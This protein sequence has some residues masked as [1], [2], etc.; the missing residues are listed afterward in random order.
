ML[1]G[2]PTPRGVENWESL[3]PGERASVVRQAARRLQ[4]SGAHDQLGSGVVRLGHGKRERRSGSAGGG[5]VYEPTPVVVVFVKKKWEESAGQEK[6]GRGAP[7]AVPERLQMRVRV[8]ERRI[9]VAMPTDV[10]QVHPPSLHALQS[11]CVA[12]AEAGGPDLPG[13]VSALVRDV[14]DSGGRLYLL[15]CHHVICR[16]AVTPGATARLDVPIHAVDAGGLRL[17]TGK[18]PAQ[19]G[20]DVLS[21]DAALVLLEDAGKA[22][23]TQRE[24]WRELARSY[25]TDAEHLDVLSHASWRLAS[26]S[27]LKPLEYVRNSFKVEIPYGSDAVKITLAEL[28]ES[29]ATSAPPTGGDSGGAVLAGQVLV[30]VH[31]AGQGAMS[32]A[33]PA[34]QLFSTVAFSPRLELASQLIH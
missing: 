13:S 11:A 22:L 16:S 29:R 31:I 17:G 24:F 21:I 5:V 34:Y 28:I 4:R 6:A 19:F 33:V 20:P 32:F 10:C 23:V 12:A 15:G 8:G 26:R 1:F 2:E 7:S 18:R 14:G 30:G 9:V 27:G 25:V 3:T